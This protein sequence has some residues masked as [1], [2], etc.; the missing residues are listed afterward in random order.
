MR[1]SASLTPFEEY[2]RYPKRD[3]SYG[4]TSLLNNIK[5]KLAIHR[6]SVMTD[7]A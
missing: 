3:L 5:N 6:I 4:D 2:L 7:D 1:L